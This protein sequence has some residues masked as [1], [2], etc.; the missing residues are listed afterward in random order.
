MF[1][2]LVLPD[3]FYKYLK[4]F[5]LKKKKKEENQIGVYHL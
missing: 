4:P 5:G 2:K 1:S 3:V